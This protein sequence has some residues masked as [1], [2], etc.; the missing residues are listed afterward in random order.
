MAAAFNGSI[1]DEVQLRHHAQF[2]AVRQLATQEASGALQPMLRFLALTIQPRKENLGM[3]VIVSHFDAGNGHQTHTRVVYLEPH[4][5]GQL[6]LDLLGDTIS[7]D[8]ICHQSAR[9]TSTIS[10]TSSLSPTTRSL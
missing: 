10:Y 2:Q 8:K 3:R 1:V 5:L 6:A 7:S 4:Q 9:A